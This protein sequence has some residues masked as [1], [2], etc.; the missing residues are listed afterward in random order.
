LASRLLD[1]APFEALA[2]EF[3]EATFA[4]PDGPRW[5]I[6]FGTHPDQVAKRL[7]AY[8]SDDD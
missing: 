6:L 7:K 5:A 3:A 1:S 4:E 2:E 8:E